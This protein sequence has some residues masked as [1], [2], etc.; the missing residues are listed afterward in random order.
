[1]IRFGDL[2]KQSRSL[3][4]EMTAKYPAGSTVAVRYDPHDKR[5]TLETQ[6][7]GGSQI[8]TGIFFIAVPLAIVIGTSLILFLSDEQNASLPP[9]VLEQLNKAN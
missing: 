2:E 9:E 6:S 8:G 3:A 1:V 7:A 5:A 4:E